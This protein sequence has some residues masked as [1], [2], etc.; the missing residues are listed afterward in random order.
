MNLPSRDHRELKSSRRMNR[1]T[2]IESNLL[3]LGVPA[4]K[5]A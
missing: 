5:G 3:T 4:T 2:A 1:I